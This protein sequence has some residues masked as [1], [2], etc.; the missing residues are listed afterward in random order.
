MTTHSS[1]RIS[2]QTLDLDLVYLP[3]SLQ[4]ELF[5]A[6]KLSPVEVL[7]AQI[8]AWEATNSKVNATTFTHFEKARGEARESENRWMRGNARPLEGITCALKD[9]HH[10]AGMIV[11]SGSKLLKDNLQDTTD[12]VTALLKEAGVVT[13]MQTTVPEFYFHGLTFSDHWGVTRNPWNLRYTVGGSSGGTG[14]ALAAGMTTLGTGS[15]MGGSIR[16]PSAYC[17]L[18]GFKPPFGR[19]S[20]EGPLAPFS[21]TG[22]MARTFSDMVLMQ[23]AMAGQTPTAPFTLPKQELPLTYS[24][25]SGMRIA[26]CV[27]LGLIRIDPE[28]RAVCDAAVQLFLD[29]GAT[30]DVI[31]LDLGTN[32]DEIQLSFVAICASGSMG[33][34]LEMEFADHISEMSPYAQWAFRKLVERPWRGTHQFQFE[35]WMKAIY[36]RL[37]KQVWGAGYDALI[38]S[39]LVDSHVPADFDHSLLDFEIDGEVAP[40]TFWS[41][42]TLPWNMLN[43]LP[44]TSVPAGL[45]SQAMPVGLQIAASPFHDETVMRLC[46]AYEKA[47]TPLFHGVLKPDFCLG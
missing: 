1:H 2:Q 21:G 6:R 41:A 9:E 44:V 15:D 30:V 32:M 43:T 24:S 37:H 11:T 33:G 8:A 16:L 28:T 23:N 5:R 42:L 47:A 7:E 39:T 10:E 29:L 38:S 31:P 25:I 18:Y 35:V 20:S 45:T 34:G 40:K 12:E 36:A 3:A 17:G 26:Y 46:H 27:D 13:H 4:L 22:P 14:A 19:I